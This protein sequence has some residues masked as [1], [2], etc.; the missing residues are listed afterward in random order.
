MAASL[1]PG[2]TRCSRESAC[3][4]WSGWSSALAL[5]FDALALQ[6]LEVRRKQLERQVAESRQNIKIAETVLAGAGPDCRS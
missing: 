4:C 5:V 1:R 6:P 3:W 2:S